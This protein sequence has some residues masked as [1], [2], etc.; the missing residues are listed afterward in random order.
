MTSRDL[1][2]TSCAPRRAQPRLAQSAGVAALRGAPQPAHVRP[3][4]GR[5]PPSPCSPAHPCRLSPPLHPRF[6]SLTLAALLSHAPLPRYTSLILAAGLPLRSTLRAARARRR[7]RPRRAF[8][9]RLSVDSAAPESTPRGPSRDG[10][11]A[12]AHP[13]EPLG[14]LF[15]AVWPRAPASTF[16]TS[17]SDR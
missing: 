1:P 11:A 7:A 8:D 4:A 3:A 5:P 12:P 9:N 2:V 17:G 16:L 10:L 6:T 13:L 14:S 15:R